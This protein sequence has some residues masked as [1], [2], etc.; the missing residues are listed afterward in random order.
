LKFGRFRLK[1]GRF[2]GV[3]REKPRIFRYKSHFGVEKRGFWGVF[4]DEKHLISYKIHVLEVFFVFFRF[5][6]TLSGLKWHQYDISRDFVVESAIF[7]VFWG[8]GGG[9]TPPKPVFT[10]KIPQK[11]QKTGFLT[12]IPPL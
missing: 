10:P 3:F 5:F 9:V 2:W 1:V 11:P 12:P 8:F 7:D 6:C 4:F